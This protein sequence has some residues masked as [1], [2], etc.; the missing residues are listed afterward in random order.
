MLGAQIWECWS[1]QAAQ[2][3]PSQQTIISALL[4]GAQAAG[5]SAGSWGRPGEAS[6]PTPTPWEWAVAIPE[7]GHGESSCQQ[8][9]REM[10]RNR[11]WGVGGKLRGEGG[12]GGAKSWSF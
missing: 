9:S 6:S 8:L 10:S 5:T 3:P 1:G 12:L 4:R 7:A 2:L 11:L